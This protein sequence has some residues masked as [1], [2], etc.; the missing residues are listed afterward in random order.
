[1]RVMAGDNAVTCLHNISTHWAGLG[2]GW[3]VIQNSP[4][5]GGGKYNQDVNIVSQAA[6][7]RGGHRGTF[8]IGTTLPE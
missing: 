8:I 1:M 7:A 4:G 3:R 5:R 2:A 6:G